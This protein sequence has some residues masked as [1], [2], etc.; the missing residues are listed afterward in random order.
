MIAM[1][2]Y[3][4]FASFQTRFGR[5]PADAKGQQFAMSSYLQYQGSKLVER[6]DANCYVRLTDSMD[7]HDVARGR[8]DYGDVLKSIRQP[9][10]VIGIESDMLYPLAEQRELAEG[11]PNAE[12]LILDAHHGHDSFLIEVSELNDMVTSWSGRVLG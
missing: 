1:A 8:G 7:T 11:M 6:F 4:S 9:A 12:F 5:E 2:T 10:L 3:R